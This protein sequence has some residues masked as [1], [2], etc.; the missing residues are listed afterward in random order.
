MRWLQRAETMGSVSQSTASRVSLG[1]RL[2]DDS[3]G[4]WP[5]NEHAL[6]AKFGSNLSDAALVEYLLV[7]LGWIEIAA[8]QGRFSVR[9]RP[10]VVTQRGLACLFYMLFDAAPPRVLLSVFGTEW[11]HSIHRTP[12]GVATI[13]GGMSGVV[14]AGL[15]S[16]NNALMSRAIAPLESPLFAGVSSVSAQLSAVSEIDDLAA[17][18]DLAFRGRWCVCHVEAEAVIMDRVGQGFTLFNPQWHQ[19]ATG[20]SLDRYADA[21]YGAWIASQRQHIARTRETVY[22]Q[23]DAIVHFPRLGETRLQY[24]RA[25]FPVSLAGGAQYIVSAAVSDSGINLRG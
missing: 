22:D 14:P 19:Q 24:A 8:A 9:C 10:R 13:I 3:G 4:L 12:Q 15:V 25:T 6:R 20:P 5:L 2:I 16:T 7:N 21:N 18:L 11:Q 23:V 17:P 1:R